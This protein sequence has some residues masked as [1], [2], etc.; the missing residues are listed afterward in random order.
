MYQGATGK[1]VPFLEGAGMP[2]PKYHNPADY[3]M[4]L[5]N[6]LSTIFI[7]INVRPSVH[8]AMVKVLGSNN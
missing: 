1:L 2:C 3:G 8:G 4:Y 5:Y 7:R 6:A